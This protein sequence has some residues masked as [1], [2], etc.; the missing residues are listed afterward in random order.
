VIAGFVARLNGTLL[1]RI[2]RWAEADLGPPPCPYAWLAFGS[3]GRMEQ[4]LLT[5]QDNALAYGEDTPEARA[6]FEQLAE[7][8]NSDLEAAGFP[9]C[10]GGYMARKWRAS[11]VE[12]EERF[13]GWVDE[14]KPQALLEAA[15]FFDFRRAHGELDV[16]PLEA[17]VRRAKGRHAF[18][19]AMAKAALQFRPPGMFLSIQSDS[20]I[21]LKFQGISPIVFLARCY[22]IEAGAPERNTLARLE[23][24][25]RGG[26]IGDDVRTTLREAY[27]FLLALRLREQIRMLAAGKPPT[28]KVSLAALSSIERSRIKESFRAIR[29][30]QEKAAYHYRTEM[31]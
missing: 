6:Y 13:R 25:V 11:L 15:I 30:W 21:D 4:T 12:W 16:A 27:R 20:E 7:L 8:A 24:A 19:A 10:P 5:D 23:A 1:S 9:S 2:L 22:A 29:G 26:L 18:I 14:P 28:N 31:F 3:E 17:A